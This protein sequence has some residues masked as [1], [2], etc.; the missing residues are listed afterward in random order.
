MTNEALKR[1]MQEAQ[2]VINLLLIEEFN[3]VTSLHNRYNRAINGID[4]YIDACEKEIYAN[5]ILELC[6]TG[7]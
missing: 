3:A 1:E 6:R 7:K 4:K 5:S 2:D